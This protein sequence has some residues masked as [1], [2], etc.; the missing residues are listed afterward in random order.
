MLVDFL[1]F[2]IMK[3]DVEFELDNL[4]IILFL[5]QICLLS[6]ILYFLMIK[7]W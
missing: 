5:P 3:Y 2:A 7:A 1:Y 6:I 4:L